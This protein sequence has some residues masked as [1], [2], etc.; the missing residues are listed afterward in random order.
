VRAEAGEVS[1]T[2]Y[3]L[4]SM[5]IN[6]VCSICGAS[7]G[8]SPNRVASAKYCS[9]RC[10]GDGF[11]PASLADR[12]WAKVPV[13][14]DDCWLFVGCPSQTYGQFEFHDRRQLAH[15]VSW[16]LINGPIPAGLEVC[17]KCDTPRCVRP[18]HLFLGTAKD[19]AQDSSRKGR[20]YGKGRPWAARGERIHTARL[21]EAI[22]TEIRREY[23][24][25]PSRG[26]VVRLGE[27]YG[28]SHHT[29]GRALRGDTWKHVQPEAL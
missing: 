12:L 25:D 27:R 9:R 28:V 5:P 23:S 3:L 29:I 1:G 11:S 10:Q 7:F 22:V 14:G 17:H 26:S 8:V 18:D 20:R 4:V 24:A 16:E 13:R 21:T 6:V 19:N 15:R 2:E